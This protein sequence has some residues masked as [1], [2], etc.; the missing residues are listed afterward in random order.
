MDKN[1]PFARGSQ[2]GYG[3]KAALSRHTGVSLF[4]II[5]KALTVHENAPDL[6]E[7]VRL[8]TASLDV[9]YEIALSRRD[10]VSEVADEPSS[11]LNDGSEPDRQ[12]AEATGQLHRRSVRSR[13]LATPGAVTTV[14]EGRRRGRSIPGPA[15]TC[16]AAP[17]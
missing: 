9:A 2:S 3:A 7:G 14:V 15:S 17:I 1:Q 13:K 12:L 8:G 11:T 6:A 4:P 16:S 5:S 10:G